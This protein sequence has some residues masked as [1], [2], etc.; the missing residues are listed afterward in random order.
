MLKS[1]Q[2]VYTDFLTSWNSLNQWIY[3]IGVAFL[4][5]IWDENCVPYE[6]L[7]NDSKSW[8]LSRVNVDFEHF[9]CCFID[10]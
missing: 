3:Q 8:K 9:I 7:S 1:T 10:L 6:A 2:E 5:L 4:K